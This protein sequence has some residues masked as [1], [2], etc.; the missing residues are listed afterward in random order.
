MKLS[1]AR[2]GV[3]LTV[4]GQRANNFMAK[5]YDQTARTHPSLR[6]FPHV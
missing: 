5:G 6:P 2:D 1:D 4:H 3:H